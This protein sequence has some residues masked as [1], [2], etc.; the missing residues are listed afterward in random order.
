LPFEEAWYR[1]RGVAAHY[2]GHP[3]F[4]ELPRQQLDPAFLARH[5]A[6]PG[7]IV[8]LLPGSRHQEVERNLALLLGAAERIHAER[9]DTRFLAACYKPSQQ[10]L[11][12][13]HLQ[14]HRLPIETVCGRTPEV[15]HLARACVAVSGSVGLELLYRATPTVVVYRVRPIDLKVGRWVMTSPFI[16]LV[17]LLAEKELFPEFLTDR[18]E[19]DAVS[20][21]ILGWLNDPDAHAAACADLV[22]LRQRVAEP[23]A[24]ERAAQYLLAAI[25]CPLPVRASA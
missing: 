21:P 15:I 12:D 3:F 23:G 22:A 13:A 4:D 19:A 14:K 1:E 20:R 2:V 16:S 17:N 18:D 7:P 8:G 24:C 11:V 9:P 25:G 6:R 5:Q 10:E